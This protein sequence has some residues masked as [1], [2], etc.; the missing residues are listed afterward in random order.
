MPYCP[1]CD[2]EFI[3]G[4]TI[5]SDCK[6]PLVA[7]KE[8]ALQQKK[9]EEQNRRE[10]LIQTF[11]KNH[12]EL[13][14]EFQ[15]PEEIPF[16][17]EDDIARFLALISSYRRPN[18]Q[19]K[20]STWKASDD[21]MS[22]IDQQLSAESN[23]NPSSLD[24]DTTLLTSDFDE[25][26][27]NTTLKS[28][29]KRSSAIENFDIES[30][31]RKNSARNGST[32]EAK[33]RARTGTPYVK[34]SERYNDLKSSANAFLGVGAVL[35][36]VSVLGWIGALP[37]PMSGFSRYLFLGVLTIMGAFSLIIAVSTQKSA[38]MAKEAIVSEEQNTKDIIN[39]FLTNWTSE[40]LD[41]QIMQESGELS[42]EERSLKRFELIQDYLVTG[43]DIPDAS[44]VD[45][46]TEEIYNTMFTD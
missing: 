44:Y 14:P 45:E 38:K 31:N 15:F 43:K 30:P 12:P 46:L 9:E 17:D 24:S 6:G 1:K 18:V 35:L 22:S 5:C 27:P 11:R 23:M 16:Q 39:W 21:L 19:R 7:S 33:T 36:V 10:T 13:P 37:M 26:N 34:Q 20:P 41:Q 29:D 28:S 3:E 40:M 42:A 8:L 2:M 4:I 32:I 25:N